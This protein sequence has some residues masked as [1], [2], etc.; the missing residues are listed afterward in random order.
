MKF[1]TEAEL[2]EY[3]SNIIG[4]TFK[5]IDSENL[6]EGSSLT[7]AKGLLGHVVET[8]FY[9]YPRNS[10]SRSDFEELDIELKVDE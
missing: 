3:T 10:D 5:E 8:G 6:L 2:L 1:K 9:K 4:K 7:K